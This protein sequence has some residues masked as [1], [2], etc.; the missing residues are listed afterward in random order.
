M[1]KFK[2]LFPALVICTVLSSCNNQVSD[3]TSQSTNTETISSLQYK[4]I[5][6]HDQLSPSILKII[7][8]PDLVR[9]V[10]NTEIKDSEIG[11]EYVDHFKFF[12]SLDKTGS[13]VEEVLAHDGY[14]NANKYVVYWRNLLGENLDWPDHNSTTYHGP[15]PA[16][17]HGLIKNGK[18]WFGLKNASQ[19]ADEYYALALKSWHKG[20]PADAPEQKDAWAWLARTAHFVQ[21]VTVPHHTFSLARIDQL[22][23]HPFEKAVSDNFAQ[24]FPSRNYDGGLW[25]GK[26][27]Y[28]EGNNKWGIYYNS[29]LPGDI[30][31]NNAKI[32]HGLFK[33]ANHKDDATN[34]NWDKV[35]A[36]VVPLA[37]K[38]CA[39]L[40]VSFLQQVGEKP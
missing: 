16:L 19:K 26:G 2:V 22:T 3:T 34:G 25:N 31:N 37:T 38:T 4:S 28:P 13:G 33:I 9:S 27:P 36:L 5:P 24:Y 6:Y 14:V 23:H 29:R 40:V 18:G 30:I 8:A 20:L 35:R 39:G 10:D 21:D 15:F 12:T 11:P 17:E 1:I 7:D 32:S